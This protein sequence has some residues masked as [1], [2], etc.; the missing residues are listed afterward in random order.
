MRSADVIT[1]IE[2]ATGAILVLREQRERG[3]QRG[4]A[5]FESLNYDDLSR[6]LEDL[7]HAAQTV[8]PPGRPCPCCKGTGASGTN[9]G[10]G[11][12]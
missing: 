1:A 4:E 2:Y 11:R 12:P 9:V 3:T 10:I 7:I 8:L 5:S 6:S